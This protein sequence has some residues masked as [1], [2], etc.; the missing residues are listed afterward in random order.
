MHLPAPAPP[1]GERHHVPRSDGHRR[2]M[3]DR[4]VS[5]Q[6]RA[7]LNDVRLFQHVEVPGER[8]AVA[9]VLRGRAL[10]LRVR[11]A[12]PHAPRLHARGSLG[13]TPS[14]AKIRDRRDDPPRGLL[15]GR[16]RLVQFFGRR[17]RRVGLFF[18]DRRFFGRSFFGDAFLRVRFGTR[19]RDRL[20]KFLVLA[21]TPVL[22][23]AIGTEV[24]LAHEVRLRLAIAP[25]AVAGDGG[26]RA[27]RTL[28]IEVLIPL[29]HARLHGPLASE[30]VVKDDGVAR[31]QYNAAAAVVGSER[32]TARNDQHALR[33]VV[34]IVV[35]RELPAAGRILRVVRRIP[36]G[37]VGRLRDE[38]GSH[39]RGRRVRDEPFHFA[40]CSFFSDESFAAM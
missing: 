38:V 2:A 20:A 16:P 40:A 15:V 11:V 26:G 37:P 27:D 32:G 34:P 29:R 13:R 6:R 7:A 19:D 3:E 17:G 36:Q 10:S 21:R 5:R 22:R 24:F 9:V 1:L 39:G 35:E 28:G 25:A 31:I 4:I 14:A 23:V 8:S 33:R 18:L 30:A 12:V